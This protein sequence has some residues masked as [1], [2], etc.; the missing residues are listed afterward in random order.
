MIKRNRRAAKARTRKRRLSVR[1][2]AHQLDSGRCVWP[3]CQR[4]VS[5]EFAHA[6]EI[7]W[8]SR[9]GDPCDLDNVVTLCG[10]THVDIHPRVGGITKKIEG[11]RALGL[12]F[13]E[14]DG[15]T[16]RRVFVA[17]VDGG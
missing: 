16:W 3:T 10:A 6:H 11:S 15:D 17:Q 12:R 5:L 9:G 14:R 1:A 13:F 8:R 2:A 7:V 4:V